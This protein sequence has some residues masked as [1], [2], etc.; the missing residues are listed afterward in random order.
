MHRAFFG[1]HREVDDLV[2]LL[3]SL[4][5]RGE[6]QI[7]VMVGPSGCGKSSL[8]RAGLLPAMANEPGWTTLTPFTPGTDPVAAL[9]Q[10]LAHAARSTPS[11]IRWQ[12]N[13][14]N[15]LV[16]AVEDLLCT[17]ASPPRRRLLVVIDQ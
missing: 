12:L 4:A 13:N 16:L 11:Q 7:V 17:G 2:R 9:S 8:V 10:E 15:G 14:D 1:R 3:R 6:G 5:K